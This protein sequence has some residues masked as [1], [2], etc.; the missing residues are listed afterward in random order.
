ML[1]ENPI[2]TLELDADIRSCQVPLDFDLGVVALA[3]PGIHCPWS[4]IAIDDAAGKALAIQ[5]RKLSFACM[6]PI[7][8]FG[9]V[10]PLQ[11]VRNPTRLWW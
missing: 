2:A 4:G 3:F 10:V 9:W 8:V 1:I 7:A 6:L 5:R 11:L